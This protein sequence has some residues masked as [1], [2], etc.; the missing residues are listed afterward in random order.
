MKKDIYK[1][2]DEKALFSSNQSIFK[3]FFPL[4]IRLRLKKILL[5]IRDPIPYFIRNHE[6]KKSLILKK[7]QQK[8]LKTGFSKLEGKYLPFYDEVFSYWSS[9]SRE[10]IKNIKSTE[11]EYS[12]NLLD[13]NEILNHLP[14]LNFALSH[15]I[16]SIIGQYLGT[17]PSLHS[18]NLWWGCAGKINAGSPFFHLDSLDNSCIRMYLYLSDVDERSGPFC[19]IPRK[20][21]FSFIRKTG[22]L[23]N[24]LSDKTVFKEIKFESLK[25]LK[26]AAGSIFAIDATNSLHYG[27]RCVEK[28]RVAM[29]FSYASYHNNEKTAS[30][31]EALPRL[32]DAT[33]LQELAYKHISI[34]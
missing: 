27:S 26:G 9:K 12:K 17:A 31:L 4:D 19:V 30:F 15:E 10:L 20:E 8:I 22:Y 29:I 24:S 14:T 21:T 6:L 25:I 34:K 3:R 32:V 28:D 18:V 13:S 2:E 1:C 11:L 16:L 5:V 7:P 23:G 33:P